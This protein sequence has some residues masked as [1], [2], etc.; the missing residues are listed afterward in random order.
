MTIVSSSL[1]PE[2]IFRVLG[3]MPQNV[4]FAVKSSLVK[5]MTLMLPVV[6]TKA[7]SKKQWLTYYSQGGALC[8]PST[9]RACDEDA[10][11][12]DFDLNFPDSPCAR[13]F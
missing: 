10:H 8:G 6:F 1:D 3:T 7:C 11:A 4:N 2:N 9:T 12:S 13:K 5:N